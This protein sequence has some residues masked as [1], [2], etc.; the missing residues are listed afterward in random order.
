MCAEFTC[1]CITLFYTLFSTISHKGEKRKQVN[2]SEE[3]LLE[4]HREIFQKEYL[5]K[6]GSNSSLLNREDYE[7]IKRYFQGSLCKSSMECKLLKRAKNANM[8]YVVFPG[9]RGELVVREVD[10]TV[11]GEQSNEK[12]CRGNLTYYFHIIFVVIIKGL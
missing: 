5:D 12:L 10:E 1:S 9:G 4:Q 6:C 7:R 3:S 8:H 11:V 2:M